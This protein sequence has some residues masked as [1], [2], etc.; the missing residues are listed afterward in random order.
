MAKSSAPEKVTASAYPEGDQHL[1]ESENEVVDVLWDSP[2]AITANDLYAEISIR[3][4]TIKRELI[5]FTTVDSIIRRLVGRG[6]IRT[7]K[8]GPRVVVYEPALTRAQYAGYAMNYISESILKRG[9][10]AVLP[11]LG[12]LEG[13]KSG[14]G[15]NA[16]ASAED[17]EVQQL[18]D[19]ISD[20]AK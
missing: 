10:S 5:S 3:R 11:R 19:T 1:S 16:G 2:E 9:L 13:R 6:V 12:G 7:I 15:K 18:L 14:S 20:L 4:R 17:L 8:L